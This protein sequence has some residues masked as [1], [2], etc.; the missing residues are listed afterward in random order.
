M[1]RTRKSLMARPPRWALA[2]CA[3]PG[4][5]GTPRTLLQSAAL[6]A[7]GTTALWPEARWW[8]AW[9]DATLDAIVD[10]AL[11][12]APACRPPRSG[13]AWRAS[14]SRPRVPWRSRRASCR[15]S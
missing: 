4:P 5:A 2:A 10:Q 12:G 9:G 8:S 13:C 7:D 11:A 6:G 15:S 1:S 3:T 14:P